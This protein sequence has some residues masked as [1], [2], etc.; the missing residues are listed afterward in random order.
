MDSRPL[1]IVGLAV[2]FLVLAQ[3]NDAVTEMGGYKK[4]DQSPISMIVEELLENSGALLFL[5][6]ALALRNE[7]QED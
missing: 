7:K 1:L 5:L 2:G 3:V 4:T 6:A